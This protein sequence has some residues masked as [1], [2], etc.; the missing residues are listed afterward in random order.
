MAICA[1]AFN[2]KGIDNT[3]NQNGL[4]C[5]KLRIQTVRRNSQ[6]KGLLPLKKP[7]LIRP[8]HP[9]RNFGGKERKKDRRR[10]HPGIFLRNGSI[11]QKLRHAALKLCG[12]HL[13]RL[14]P[15]MVVDF[16]AHA[17]DGGSARASCQFAASLPVLL[18][19]QAV[20]A[21]ARLNQL[22]FFQHSRPFQLCYRGLCV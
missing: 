11:C 22:A 4:L 15:D 9:R 3:L 10:Q 12:G 7:F 5:R 1:L 18:R 20:C 17:M 8:G 19:K 14:S 2:Q 6:N 16:L 13:A 21:L